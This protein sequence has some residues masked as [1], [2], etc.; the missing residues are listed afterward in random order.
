MSM[1]KLLG[2]LLSA[3]IKGSVRGLE[4]VL[5]AIQD[6]VESEVLDESKV[7]GELM[8]LALRQQAGEIDGAEYKAKEDALL[9]RLNEIRRY[10]E[11]LAE[12]EADVDGDDEVE[13]D[14]GE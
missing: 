10:K 3:P 13:E 2:D 4:F 8:Q 1:L 6:E 9:E 11:S 14:D 5:N 12:E 7:Q